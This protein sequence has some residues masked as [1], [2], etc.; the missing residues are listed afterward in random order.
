MVLAPMNKLKEEEREHGVFYDDDYNYLQHM[1]DRNV[2]E[3]D[4]SEADRFVMS[5][6][7]RQLNRLQLPASVFGTQGPLSLVPAIAQWQRTHQ[8]A[9]CTST[10]AVPECPGSEASQPPE[11]KGT[12]GL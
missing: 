7:E 10:P 11:Y 3:H 9:H 6:E 4:W 8:R 1:K 5:A 2:V 12:Q